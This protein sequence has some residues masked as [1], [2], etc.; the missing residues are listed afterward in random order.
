MAKLPSKSWKI[1]FFII[2]YKK[3]QNK[4]ARIR[5]FD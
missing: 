4:I 5:T 3:I 1:E 2:R